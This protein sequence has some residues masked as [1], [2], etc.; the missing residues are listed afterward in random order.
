MS[1]S[2]ITKFC[3][4]LSV[5]ASM[6]LIFFLSGCNFAVTSKTA[7]EKAV[8]F[9]NENFINDPSGKAEAVLSSSKEYSVDLYEVKIAIMQNKEKKS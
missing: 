3:S 8:K 4:M 6:F 5:L 1:K 9:I 2:K 7:G